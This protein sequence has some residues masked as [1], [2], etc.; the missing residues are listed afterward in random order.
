[1]ELSLGS[2]LH[3]RT[4]SLLAS[5]LQPTAAAMALLKPSKFISSVGSLTP[6]L[7]TLPIRSSSWWTEVQMG[8][9]D[10]ILG[11]TEAF[12]R[13]TNSKKMNLGVGAYRDDNGKPYVLSCVR[14]A[15]ALI[16]SKML[17]KEYLPIGGLGDF[18]KACAELA[19]G[20]DSEVLKSKRSITV[21]TISGTGSLRIGANF[22]SRFHTVARDVYLPKPSWG[23]HTP[24]FRDAGMQLK[25][26][27]YYDPATCGFDFTGALD[28]I[29]K[30]PEHSVIML[31]ACAHNPTGVDPRPEQ[32]KELST[33][34]KKRKLLVFFDM[35]YQGFA[36]G[37]IDRDAWAV[38][39]FLEQGH[40]VLLSQSFAKNMGLYGERVGGFTVV[41]ADAEEAKRV[42]SQLKILI[43]PIYSNPPM[44]GARIASTILSTPELRSTWLEEVKGMADRIIKMRE[45]LVTNLKKEGSTHNWQ[46]V[47]DQIGM[48]C[49]TGLKPEQV[50]R[51]TKE[52][53]V[54]MT[55][56]GRISVAGVTS[57]NVGYL[58]HAIHQV[59]K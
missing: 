26:Y 23:N 8:P 30:I 35:A 5:V 13:D 53:S 50:E 56:D 10:P 41:C 15:E 9:P 12:K 45:M 58:A 47:I 38:R 54:Y 39:Y 32:W 18:N 1:M 16:A 2:C 29:S 42:E 43:R 4:H 52:F 19:L 57:G 46:H 59:T 20:P 51:L 25:A 24:V 6:S 22:L 3:E 34:I 48:F 27:R 44:N 40:N 17:D 55:K 37:D 36:S 31:H 21:Q 33:V 28:D 49:F 7:A 14:K 11:V